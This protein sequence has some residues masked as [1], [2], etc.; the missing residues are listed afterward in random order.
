M[1]PRYRFFNFLMPVILALLVLS[2]VMGLGQQSPVTLPEGVQYVTSVEGI[3][4]Y[5]LQNGLRVLLFPDPTKPNITVN[6]TYMVGSLYEDYGETGMAHLLEHLM[7]KGSKNHPD[8]PKELQDHGTRPNGSTSTDRTNY[9]ETFQATDENLHWALDL[10]SDRMVNA[11]ITREDLASEMTVVRN[12]FE[13]GENNPLGV[14][15]K[16]TMATAYLW[17]NYGNPVIGARSDIENVP[18]E[19][20]QAFYRNFYQPDNA[21]LVV[22]GKIDEAKTLVLVDRYFSPIP[23]PERHLRHTYTVEP[24]QDG[25]RRVT[26]RRVGDIQ[27]IFFAYHIPAGSHEEYPAVDIAT[28]II[29]DTPSGRL[30]KA[31]VETGKA[32]AAGSGS[33]Q[34]R[35]PGLA[36]GMAVIREDKSSDEA[37]H[38]MLD[39]FDNLKD[40]PFT[41]EEVER[42]KT[43]VLKSYELM[44]NNSESAALNLS[45]WQAM[46]DW[47]LLFLYR[48]RIKNV[49]REQVQQEA[50]KYFIPSN[51]TICLFYPDDKPLRAEVPPPPDVK[52]LVKDYKSDTEIAKG[53][54][55]DPSPENIEERTIR[56]D[57]EGGI[58]LS[59]LSKKSRGEQVNM[60]IT[61]YFGDEH[62]MKGQLEAAEMAGQM[63]MRGTA[64]HTRQQI[65]DTFDKLKANVSVSGGAGRA[66]VSIQTTRQNLEPTLNL[67]IEVLEEPSFPEDEFEQLKQLQLASLENQKSEPQAMALIAMMRYMSPYPKGDVRYVATLEEMI[68][69]TQALKL[70][71]LRSFHQDFY[72]ASDCL[73]TAVGDFDPDAL[74]KQI[75]GLLGAW[76]SPKNFARIEKKYQRIEPKEAAFMAPDKANAMWVAASMFQMND[77]DPDYA[78]MTLAGYILGGGM[79][80]ILFSR[81]RGKE[82]LSYGVGGEFEIPTEDDN[83]SFISYAIC[84]PQNAPKVEAVFKEILDEVL[85]K[86]FAAE[87]IEAAKQ[88]WLQLQKVNRAQDASLANALTSRRFWG[89]T[90]AFDAEL[91]RRVLSLTPGQ[92]QAA[93]RKHIDPAGISFFRAGDFEK[94]GVTWQ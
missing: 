10:E 77:T 74:E 34:R 82:G 49:T 62:S 81:I 59:L 86:G 91:E 57:L 32:A 58:K 20:L 66:D 47:R 8:I 9:F 70:E 13:A 22:A 25:E 92:L 63:L 2:P 5:R 65:T 26:L 94:A 4:E 1:N 54:E 61:L 53:E 15:Q 69:N 78:A 64:K 38:I 43:Q 93:F 76:K 42:A 85:E 35:D 30:H 29:G 56:K 36:L 83:A 80:S 60:R 11:N 89:R 17:H 31:L 52:A 73:V 55:F 3:N 44:M 14:M 68:E 72:G 90:M 71:Q 33:L 40:S 75:S 48:D 79:N 46:G 23:K 41:D 88:S 67:A 19:R 50:E 6:V 21:M 7:F 39:I 12:E 18:I 37:L 84:A 45:E 27:A 87:E 24:A 16:R 51:R 28:M